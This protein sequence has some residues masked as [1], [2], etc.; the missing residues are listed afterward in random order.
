MI[1]IITSG[2]PLLYSKFIV[3]AFRFHVTTDCIEICETFSNSRTHP[4]KVVAHAVCFEEYFLCLGT[5]ESSVLQYVRS[6]LSQRW[7]NEIHHSSFS[8]CTKRI[9]WPSLRKRY[10]AYLCISFL[11]ITIRDSIW[12][13][14]WW[15]IICTYI[16]NF[17][18]YFCRHGNYDSLTWSDTA[19]NITLT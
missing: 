19:R 2:I 5:T 18:T 14:A 7:I 13:F 8:G 12:N 4:G 15:R 16:A 11:F 1:Q 17:H 6:S 9:L 10:G 3:K